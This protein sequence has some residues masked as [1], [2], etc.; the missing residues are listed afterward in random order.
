MQLVLLTLLGAFIGWFTNHLAVRMLFRPRRPW[1]FPG[2]P[3]AVQGVLPRRR[4][5]LITAISEAVGRELL[6]ADY[7]LQRVTAPRVRERIAGEVAATVA[8][9]VAEAL[10][11]FLPRGLSDMAA[12]LLAEGARREVE[13]FFA[14]DLPGLLTGMRRELDLAAAVRERLEAVSFD[15]LEALILRLSHRELRHIEVMGGLI[16]AAVGLVEALLANA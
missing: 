10:P 3:W 14:I 12:R 6:P 2:L 8:R 13:R 4:R 11:S 5:E 9:R 7:L 1:R 15:E 16:G